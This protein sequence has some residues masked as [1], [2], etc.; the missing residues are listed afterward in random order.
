MHDHYDQLF[1]QLWE[2]FPANV[3][4]VFQ[5]AKADFIG[6]PELPL[7]RRSKELNTSK[8]AFCAPSTFENSR[9]VSARQAMYINIF[10]FTAQCHFPFIFRPIGSPAVVGVSR[11]L[12]GARVRG[13]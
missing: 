3:S 12:I 8:M 7:W 13:V 2:Y 9:I 6:S 4:F 11:Y 1:Q 10:S 5:I